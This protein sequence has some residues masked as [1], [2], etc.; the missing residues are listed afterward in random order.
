MSRGTWSR[1]QSSDYSFVT[2]DT[3]SHKRLTR[4]TWKS[5]I[6]QAYNQHEEVISTATV[7][8]K[9]RSALQRNAARNTFLSA[10]GF[11]SRLTKSEFMLKRNAYSV[12]KPFARL[13]NRGAHVFSVLRYASHCSPVTASLL[14]YGGVFN[15]L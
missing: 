6:V 1:T 15:Q 7:E 14:P 8:K 9:Q 13:S 3:S 11:D 12:E 4:A 5:A 10:N 2:A